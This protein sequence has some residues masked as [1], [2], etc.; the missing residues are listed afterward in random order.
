[1]LRKRKA[2]FL[3]SVAA[4]LCLAETSSHPVTK[5]EIVKWMTG[6][7]SNW[8]RWG[9]T[10]QVGAVNFITDVKRREAAGLGARACPYRWRIIP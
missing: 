9:K 1:M 8:G 5:G 7:C 4:L 3:L 6:E 2:V 10:D